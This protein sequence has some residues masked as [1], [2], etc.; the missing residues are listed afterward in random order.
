MSCL[1][2]P[3]RPQRLN[4]TVRA[5]PPPPLYTLEVHREGAG[6]A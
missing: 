4:V 5:T 6:A 3:D 2:E 1:K